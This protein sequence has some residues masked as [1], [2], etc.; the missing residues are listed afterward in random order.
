VTTDSIAARASA[1]LHAWLDAELEKESPSA[2]I[3]QPIFHYTDAAGLNGI[4]ETEQLWFTSIFHQNDPSE[5]RYGLGLAFEELRCLSQFRSMFPPKERVARA[6]RTL[7]EDCESV[8]SNPISIEFYVASFSEDQD[9]LGQW[10][11]Y[12][13][14]GR[15]FATGFAPTLFKRK[16][17]YGHGPEALHVQRISYEEGHARAQIKPVISKAIEVITNFM[18]REHFVST[19]EEA[20]LSKTIGI[21]LATGIILTALSTKHRA[22]KAEKEWRLILSSTG[23]ASANHICTR[24]R[25]SRLVPY[26]KL[27]MPIREPGNITKIVI[28]PAADGEAE[29]AVKTL[30]KRYNLASS[31]DVRRSDIPYRSMR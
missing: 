23:P 15:G 20:D 22:Y 26:I 16:P 13:D 30:L 6:I 10:R 28:G 3:T 9:E 7:C 4:F 31:V 14:D 11:G 29:H 2:E 27:D 21:G 25:G 19:E 24:Q 5:M 1:E 12:G 17:D 18:T 8:L